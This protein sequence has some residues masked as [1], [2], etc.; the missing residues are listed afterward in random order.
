MVVQNLEKGYKHTKIG[1]IP[2][3]WSI[4]SISM[5]SKVVRGGSPR[6]AGDPKYFKGNFIPWLTVAAL[7]NI[8]EYQVYVNETYDFL[9]KEGSKFSR[10]LSKKTL[11]ISNSGATLGVAKILKIKCCANDGIAALLEIEKHIHPLY[12]FYY[13]NSITQKLRIIATGNGQPNLNTALIGE[14]VIP[15]PSSKEEQIAIIKILFDIDLLLGSF[16]NLIVTLYLKCTSDVEFV[17][18]GKK[19]LF[20]III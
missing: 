9:T 2:E 13:L 3:D 17:F 19:L 4:K 14:V 16:D 8:P 11:I 1:V 18:F 7:T 15:I 20:S 12:L 6:P 10:T 5:I